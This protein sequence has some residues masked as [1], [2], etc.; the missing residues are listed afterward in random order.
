[1]SLLP[2]C[3]RLVVARFRWVFAPGD[4]RDAEILAVLSTVFDRRRLRDVL[5][6][7]K[8]ATVI[9]WYRRLVAHHW[10][11]PAAPKPGRPPL[12]GE[13]RELAV[14]LAGENPTW[15]YR[16]IHGELYRLGHKVAASSIWKILRTAGINPTPSSTGPTRMEFIRSQA[17]GI[18]AT[19][20]C[21]VDTVTLRRLHVLFFIEL[22]SRRVHLTGIITNPT[23]DWTTQAARN[24]LMGVGDEFRFV[25]HDGA[26]QY[27]RA[28]D[29]VFEATAATAIT[30]PS[31]A[32]MANAYT[33]RWVR[34]LRHELLDRTIIWSG[35]HL[36][37][38]PNEYLHH[39]NQHRPHR[40]LQ[41]RA[42]GDTAVVTIAPTRTIERHAT[43]GG[44]IN[45]YHHAA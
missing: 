23:G 11:Q 3:A 41:Q 29:T 4:E 42:P 10:T 16:R 30:T 8:R 25:I 26:G 6:I 7:V 27:T 28:F 13:I 36:R 38:L 32:P 12:A 43:C 39:S 24:V 9:R 34:T 45:E 33:E 40:S 14:R 22:A 15:G 21:C 1:M 35:R 5:L 37:A 31:G 20:F 44:L 2:A 18:V 17:K 19:D